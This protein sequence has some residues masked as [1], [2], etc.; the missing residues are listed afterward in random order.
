L[1]RRKPPVSLERDPARGVLAEVLLDLD[2]ER[3]IAVPLDRDELVDRRQLAVE[4]EIDDR[5][6]HAD[7]GPGPGVRRARTRIHATMRSNRHARAER[8]R[9]H[10]AHR[11]RYGIASNRRSSNQARPRLISP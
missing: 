5:A 2:G 10:G 1:P 7:H 9:G 3:V 11:G 4:G 8:R 6:A